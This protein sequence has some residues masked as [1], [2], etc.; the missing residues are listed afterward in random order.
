MKAFGDGGWWVVDGAGGHCYYVVSVFE[1]GR[2]DTR[3]SRQGFGD[4]V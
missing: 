1:I 2:L 4:P 3:Q